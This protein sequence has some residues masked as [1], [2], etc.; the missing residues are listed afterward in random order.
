MIVTG[1]KHGSEIMQKEIFAPI[2]WAGTLNKPGYKLVYTFLT[3]KYIQIKEVY[4][5][6]FNLIQKLLSYGADL[7]SV[8]D[9]NVRTRLLKIIKDVKEMYS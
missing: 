5:N 9:E 6:E 8:E 3:K 4:T 7:V 2:E 1:I